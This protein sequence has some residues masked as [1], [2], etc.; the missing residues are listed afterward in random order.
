MFAKSEEAPVAGPGKRRTVME[1]KDPSVEPTVAPNA[2][3][4]VGPADTLA[5]LEKRLA[6]TRARLDELNADVEWQRRE[7]KELDIEIAVRKG[8]L[9]L[10][11]GRAR[12]R[13]SPAS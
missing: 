9:E 7:K 11:E 13:K 1:S 12:T 5:S 3:D 6:E 4:T 2:S 10:S 8:A